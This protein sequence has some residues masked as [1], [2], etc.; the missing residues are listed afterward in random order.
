LV[1]VL[2]SSNWIGIGVALAGVLW[3]SLLENSRG[4]GRGKDREEKQD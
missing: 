4:R 2:T 1:K 3:Y